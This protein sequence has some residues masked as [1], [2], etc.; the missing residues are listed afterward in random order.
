V[1]QKSC[2]HKFLNRVAD[3]DEIWNEFYALRDQFPILTN[4]ISNK[5]SFHT[6][7][8]IHTNSGV[9]NPFVTTLLW[10]KHF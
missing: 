9:R 3:F 1:K 5:F 10:A 7:K 8:R 6:Q 2:P 4:I